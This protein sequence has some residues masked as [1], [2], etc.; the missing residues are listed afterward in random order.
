[1]PGDQFP[2]QD[3]STGAVENIPV[4]LGFRNIMRFHEHHDNFPF[5]TFL[6]N[7]HGVGCDQRQRTFSSCSDKDVFSDR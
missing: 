6:V 1:M 5:D 4:S 2:G 3:R 7:Q